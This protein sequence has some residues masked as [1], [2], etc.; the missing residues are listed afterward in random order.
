MHSCAQSSAGEGQY[1]KMLSFSRQAF[2]RI[3]TSTG[4]AQHST[5]W[6]LQRTTSEVPRVIFPLLMGSTHSSHPERG[7][8]TLLQSLQNQISIFFSTAIV[9]LLQMIWASLPAAPQLGRSSGPQGGRGRLVAETPGT[10]GSV[11]HSH[12]LH[13]LCVGEDVATYLQSAQQL[14]VGFE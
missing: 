5:A 4:L 11:L 8:L 6:P 9:L 3:L 7:R 14:W 2:S 1:L 10:Q 12:I 13:A